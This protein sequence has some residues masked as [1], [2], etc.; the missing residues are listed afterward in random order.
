ME[1]YDLDVEI[2]G[3]T[4]LLQ[5]KIQPSEAVVKKRGEEQETEE[6]AKSRLYKLEDGTIVVPSEW[7]L[8]AMDRVSSEFKVPGMKRT[9][10]KTLLPGNVNI[11]KEA[12]PIEPQS[13]VVDE[14]TVVIPSTRGRV[15]RYRPKFPKWKLRFTF[16]VFDTRI[17]KKTLITILQEAGRR[18]GI[19]D[20]R[21]IGFGRFIVSGVGEEKPSTI[22]KKIRKL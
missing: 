18:I 19:G 21:K 1:M 16:R 4:P 10:Y 13:W 14:R 12:I 2:E 20:A 15:W 9:T 22:E 3:V 17:D 11:T 8:R 6:T 7:I 5:N